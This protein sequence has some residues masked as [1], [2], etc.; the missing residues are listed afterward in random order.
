MIRYNMRFPGRKPVRAYVDA[1][2]LNMHDPSLQREAYVG[3]VVERGGRKNVKRV[4]ARESDDAEV[5]AILFAIEELGELGRLTIVCD[6]ESVVSEARRERAK[7]PSDLLTRLRETLRAN[8]KVRLEALQA[9]PAHQVVTEYV[10][11]MKT[12]TE[13]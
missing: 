13:R 5:M 10:N 1:K 6:H 3:Y 8:P 7:N 11:A 4:E 12:P 9:N 2:I